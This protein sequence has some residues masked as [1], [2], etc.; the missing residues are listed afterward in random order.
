MRSSPDEKEGSA[1]NPRTGAK[2]HSVE[3]AR[4]QMMKIMWDRKSSETTVVGYWRYVPSVAVCLAALTGFVFFVLVPSVI[5]FVFGYLAIYSVCF[6]ILAIIN[7]KLV[8]WMNAHFR[9]EAA[10]RALLIDLVRQR[11]KQVSTSGFK[12]AFSKI[13]R[14]D[15]NASKQE[16]PRNE[17]MSAMSALP[18]VGIVFGFAFLRSTMMAQAE[19]NRNWGELLSQ[20]KATEA[21]SGR[22]LQIGN[23][24]ETRKPNLA[25]FFVLSLLC[26]PFL[27][28]WYRD[29]ER[30]AD[31]HLQ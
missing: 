14:I 23:A 2:A 11:S 15:L 13:E 16:K 6:A 8:V 31:Q 1:A 21:A 3:T 25:I 18:I 22:E 26:F 20:L 17:M 19:H 30:M 29:I 5:G 10:L 4:A 7:Y 12:E 9:R 24:R 27:A 28:Y